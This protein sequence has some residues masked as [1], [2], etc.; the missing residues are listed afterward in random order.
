MS[1][2]VLAIGQDLDGTVRRLLVNPLLGR[3]LG[4]SAQLGSQ[5]PGQAS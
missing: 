2:T 5:P 1:K 3:C 4:L